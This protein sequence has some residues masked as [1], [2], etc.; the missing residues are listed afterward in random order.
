MPDAELIIVFTK[1]ALPGAVKARLV[2]TFTPDEAAEFHLAALADTVDAA[3][4]ADRGPVELHVDGDDDDVA[5]VRALYPG[6]TVRPQ[7]GGDLGERLVHAFESTFARAVERA[8]VIGSDHPTLPPVHIAEALTRLDQADVTLGPSRDGGYY[9]VA[10][11]RAS[12]PEARVI[13]R[14]IPWSTAAVRETSMER[15]RQVELDVVLIPEWYDVDAPE[16]LETLRRDL[17]PDSACAR[18]LDEIQR[19]RT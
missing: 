10:V 2:P 8:V 12:W 5:E 14:G 1:A 9:A 17:L 11:R 15:A 7:V 3:L 18:F 13:F 6:H 19:R 4:R 16:D